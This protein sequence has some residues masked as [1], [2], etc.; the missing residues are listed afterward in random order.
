MGQLAKYAFANAKARALLSTL[1]T[2][3]SLDRLVSA[4]DATELAEELK[5]SGYY[6]QGAEAFLSTDFDLVQAERA[7]VKED[8]ALYRKVIRALQ[9][10]A[11]RQLIT[12]LMERYELDDLKFLL[13]VWHRKMDIDVEPFLSGETIIHP[14]DARKLLQCQSIEQVIIV[15]EKTPYRSALVRAIEPYKEKGSAFVLDSA[16][17]KDYYERLLIALDELS[18]VDR[19]VSG[20][21]IGIEI[22]I[23]NLTWMMRMRT[24]YNA[25]M[26]EMLD[27]VVPGGA[28]LKPSVIR[29]FSASPDSATEDV[30]ISFGPYGPLKSLTDAQGTFF[31]QFLYNILRKE[32]GRALAGFPFTIGTILGYLMLKR[33]ETRTILSLLAAKR[34]GWKKEECAALLAA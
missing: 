34:L 1:Y 33:R 32:I 16:L 27:G 19:K 5:K 18:S 9:G 22:D 14:I 20:R 8:I 31:E 23:A 6:R 2:A 10:P 7:F 30:G 3:Q 12:L 11:E 26:K 17:D 24:Y 15:L 29:D 21:L 13:R 28:H 4:G 25:G